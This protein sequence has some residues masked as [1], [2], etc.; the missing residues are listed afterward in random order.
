MR[1]HL[2][3]LMVCSLGYVF[4]FKPSGASSKIKY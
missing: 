1:F 3:S 2:L 4:K